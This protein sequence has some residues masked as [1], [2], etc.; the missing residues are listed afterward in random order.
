VSAF[1]VVRGEFD[2]PTGVLTVIEGLL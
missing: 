2:V 1:P